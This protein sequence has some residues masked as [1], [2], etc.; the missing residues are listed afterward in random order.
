MLRKIDMHM[1]VEIV[2]PPGVQ[3]R[4]FISSYMTRLTPVEQWEK[5]RTLDRHGCNLFLCALGLPVIDLQAFK[6]ANATIK[7]P[8]S[9]HA[10]RPTIALPL[11]SRYFEEDG[12]LFDPLKNAVRLDEGNGNVTKNPMFIEACHTLTDWLDTNQYPLPL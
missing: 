2:L 9:I 8:F 4:T 7:L 12:V 5:L 1:V 6:R 11:A 10:T 3:T